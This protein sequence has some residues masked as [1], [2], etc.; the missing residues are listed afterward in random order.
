MAKISPNDLTMI[1]NEVVKQM[2]P[3]IDIKLNPPKV[4]SP[5]DN[6]DLP[7]GTALN[8]NGEVI[9]TDP[10]VEKADEIEAEMLASLPRGVVA[11]RGRG[12][13][14]IVNHSKES[15]DAISNWKRN[16]RQF[17]SRTRI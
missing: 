15:M 9:Y 7:E 17:M 14:T 5:I 6:T 10:A 12:G 8:A 11:Y 1:V 4:E 2:T 13:T 3:I 16:R